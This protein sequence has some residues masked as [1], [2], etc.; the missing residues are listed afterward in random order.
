MPTEEELRD[1]ITAHLKL[2]NSSDTVA[3]IWSGYIAAL[4]EWGLISPEAYRRLC[5]L[6]PEVGYEETMELIT[7]T[8]TQEE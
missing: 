6:L 1:R 3:L 8:A 2:R 4:S 5:A 7:G